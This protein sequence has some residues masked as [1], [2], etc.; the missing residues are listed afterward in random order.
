MKL[1]ILVPAYMEGSSIGAILDRIDR[2]DLS[3]LGVEKEVIVCDDGSTD[4]TSAV[5]ERFVPHDSEVRLVRHPENRG[6]GAAIRTALQE[7]RGEICLVQDADLEYDVE[8]Y[9]QLLVPIVTGK[10]EVVFGSRFL[11][12]AVPTGMHPANFLANKLLTLLANKLFHHKITDEATCFKVFRTDVLKS[13]DLKCSGFEF[14]PEVVS[15]LGVRGVDIHEEPIEYRARDVEAGKKVRWTDGVEAVWLM[16]RI[17]TESEA[18]V[19][20]DRIKKL[21]RFGA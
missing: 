15:K 7:A 20:W 13:L 18:G 14:C 17:K 3:E 16:L 8:D 5:V 19:L 11:R 12:R 2:L 6:K 1:S 10:A 21:I 4:D 9:P